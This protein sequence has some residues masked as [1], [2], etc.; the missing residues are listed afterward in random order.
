MVRAAAA[1]LCVLVG[2]VAGYFFWGERASALALTLNRLSLEYDAVRSRASWDGPASGASLRSTLELLTSRVSEQGEALAQQTETLSRL[3]GTQDEQAQASLRECDDAQT[4]LQEQLESCLFAQA[5][6]ESEAA[7][8][9]RA[10]VPVRSGTQ[11]VT[12]SIEIPKVPPNAVKPRSSKGLG[13]WFKGNDEGDSDSKP[14]ER[15]RSKRDGEASA[16]P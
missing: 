11:T 13:G 4:R 16:L 7:A 3:T 6:L 2:L 8:A 15:E 5:R 10:T 12:E 14:L 9:K 1:S